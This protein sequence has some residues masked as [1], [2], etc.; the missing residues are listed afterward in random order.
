VTEQPPEWDDTVDFDE[1][2]AR[3]EAII[4]ERIARLHPEVQRRIATAAARVAYYGPVDGKWLA[5]WLDLG[6]EGQVHLGLVPRAA[7]RRDPPSLS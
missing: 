6:D 1:G 7:F 4:Y 5:L 2:M 3:F